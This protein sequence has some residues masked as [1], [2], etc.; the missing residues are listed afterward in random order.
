L[1]FLEYIQRKEEG[2]WFV[3]TLNDW[4]V[5]ECFLSESLLVILPQTPSM[6]QLQS[7]KGS[8]PRGPHLLVFKEVKRSLC[9]MHAYIVF[10]VDRGFLLRFL[11]D[12]DTCTSK[13]FV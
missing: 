4:P 1:L 5:E 12:I 9:F 2:E 8:I 3:T 6:N 7:S 11:G 10:F 13:R